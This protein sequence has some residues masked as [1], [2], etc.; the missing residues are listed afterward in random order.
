MVAGPPA[1]VILAAGQSARLGEPKAL[2]RLRARE[3]ATP[4]ACLL[5]AGA[6][7]NQDPPLVVAG[8]HAA[9]IR[10]ALPPTVELAE[11]AGWA[12]G[13]SGGIQLAIARRPDRDL[14]LAPID[15]PLVT[16][17][18]FDA[19]RKSWIERGAPA[20]G[21]LAPAVREAEDLRFGH[22]V[23]AGREL[24]REFLS[25]SPA[26]PLRDLRERASPLWWVEVHDR[27][28]LDDLD[29]PEDLSELRSRF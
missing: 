3:P 11:H 10:A 4:L 8:A 21:W 9:S 25:F 16:R 13:R 14:C 12:R 23:I 28:I 6:A 27:S 17:A 1:L 20:R 18:V 5:E 2:V 26:Q 7:F 22:P 19:L 24:L 29:R 15:A